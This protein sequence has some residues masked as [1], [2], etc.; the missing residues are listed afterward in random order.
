MIV[1][2]EFAPRDT[3]GVLRDFLDNGPIARLVGI[4]RVGAG[5]AP[6]VFVLLGEFQ[7]NPAVVGCS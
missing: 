4:Q 1:Q 5:R 6:E 2:A 3:F 7:T